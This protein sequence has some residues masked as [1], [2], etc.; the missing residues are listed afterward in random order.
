MQRTLTLPKIISL[1]NRTRLG[2][3]VCCDFFACL[4]LLISWVE[5]GR[6][7]LL[8]S[9]KSIWDVKFK[10]SNKEVDN[11]ME[12][13]VSGIFTLSK[14]NFYFHES[15]ICLSYVPGVL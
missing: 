7:R 6:G 8:V 12:L 11:P 4:L 10:I 9:S 2:D 14:T 15:L 5:E 1:L 13:D 3:F